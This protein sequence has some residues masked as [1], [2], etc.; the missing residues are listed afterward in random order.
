MVSTVGTRKYREWN[1][2]WCEQICVKLNCLFQV[3]VSHVTLGYRVDVSVVASA[4]ETRG[5]SSFLKRSNWVR[6]PN[7]PTLCIDVPSFESKAAVTWSWPLT[8]N[9][10]WRIEWVELNLNCSIRSHVMHSYNFWFS[11]HTSTVSTFEGFDEVFPYRLM[12]RET[13]WQHFVTFFCK[14]PFWHRYM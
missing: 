5:F 1:K 7:L 13:Y 2:F 3:A 10:C 12:H 6:P 14:W 8:S 9:L 11:P 4:A